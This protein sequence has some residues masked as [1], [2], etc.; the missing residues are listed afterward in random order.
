MTSQTFALLGV[1]FNKQLL[2]LNSR[3]TLNM[4]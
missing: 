3:P 4:P 2:L 1:W